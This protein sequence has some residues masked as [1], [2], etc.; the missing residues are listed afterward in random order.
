MNDIESVVSQFSAHVTSTASGH[1][2]IGPVPLG[3]ISRYRGKLSL[4]I[5]QMILNAAD[6]AIR[7]IALQSRESIQ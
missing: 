1:K 3:V 4:F 5:F 6:A 2:F 7:V